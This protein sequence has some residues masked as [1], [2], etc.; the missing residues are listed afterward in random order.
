MPQSL[1]AFSYYGGKFSKLKFILPQLETEHHTFVELA[2][3][4]AAVL[5]NKPQA[6]V[7][8]LNDSAQEVIAF[9]TAIRDRREELIDA[10]KNTPA[11]EAEFRRIISL[12]PA[13][14]LVETARRF[15]VHVTQSF[16][17]MPNMPTHSFSQALRYQTA[18]NNLAAVADRMRKV[19]VENTTANRLLS[20]LINNHRKGSI[21]FYADP[22]YTL[23]SRNMDS[24][25]NSKVYIHDDFDHDAFLAAVLD[26]P[27]FCKFVISG[28]DNKL[29]NTMLSDWHR[30]ELDAHLTARNQSKRRTEVLWRNYELEDAPKQSSI[31]IRR[32]KP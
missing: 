1:K 29:Y 19:V 20:R 7:E 4:S 25:I 2:C 27:D 13:D 24:K 28:Y 11:G 16:S 18:Q 14:D 10:I 26:A 9:W 30:V 32:N 22:P 3:G 5:L 12:P 23:D 8:V 21:L 17:A 6:E 15:Y 31:E